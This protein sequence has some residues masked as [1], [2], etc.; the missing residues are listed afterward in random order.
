GLDDEDDRASGRRH[1]AIAEGD[2]PPLGPHG[3]GRVARARQG[4]GPEV[5]RHVVRRRH[6]SLGCRRDA[7]LPQRGLVQAGR[8]RHGLR[9]GEA[10]LGAYDPR[11]VTLRLRDRTIEL[12]AGEPV[13]MGIVNANPDSFSDAVRLAA[14]DEQVGHARALVAEGAGI[15]DVGGE[16]GVTYTEA[17]GDDV[18]AERVVPLVRALV[19]EGIIVSVDT[20]KAAV[21]QR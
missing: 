1:A 3:H 16:S 19:A 18:E 11:Q 9:G 13:L 15:V 10:P 21:A 8:P 4:V 7:P 14:L 5:A 17:S 6:E 12:V 2:D 20:W